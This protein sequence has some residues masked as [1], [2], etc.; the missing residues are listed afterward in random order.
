MAKPTPTRDSPIR[1]TALLDIAPFGIAPFG[2]AP[3]DSACFDAGCFA[4]APLDSASSD[5]TRR[6]RAART[7]NGNAMTR[8]ACHPR[9]GSPSGGR[10]PRGYRRRRVPGGCLPGRAVTRSRLPACCAPVPHHRLVVRPGKVVAAR[11]SKAASKLSACVPLAQPVPRGE[12]PNAASREG[13]S[14]VVGSS[15]AD[16]SLAGTVQSSV[17]RRRVVGHPAP[18]ACEWVDL[19]GQGFGISHCR[20][21][22]WC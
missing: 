12:P 16:S 3:F 1:G 18:R 2:I 19:L 14:F 5:T 11:G 8:R 4:C 9:C 13:G 15:I 6:G 21:D 22:I 17:H 20:R 7:R 10:L